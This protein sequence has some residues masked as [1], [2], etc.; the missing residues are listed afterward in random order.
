MEFIVA[1][2][3]VKPA[4]IDSQPGSVWAD[5]GA[6]DGLFT[7]VLA[8]LLPAHSTIIA[9]DKDRHSL[10]KIR[11]DSFSA[12]LIKTHGNFESLIDTLSDLDGIIL[13]N[14]LH[15]VSSQS[16]F[17]KRAKCSLKSSGKIIL[18][19][20]DLDRSNPW[21]PFPVTFEQAKKL[22]DAAGFLSCA[23]IGETPSRLNRSTIYSALLM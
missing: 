23:R 13:A 21:V 4:I 5:L 15:Y 8:S 9:I 20:Y 7:R 10:D 19:E 12:T 14:A 22:A 16:D 18:I 6:G 17:L 3:L 11:I 2:D 1:Q